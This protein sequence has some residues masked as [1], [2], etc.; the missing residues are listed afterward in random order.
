MKK[1]TLFLVLLL[2][3]A[4][5]QS[6][7]TLSQ[8]AD[9]A[10]IDV[11]GI[12]CWG[13]STGQYRDNAFARTYDL[14]SFGITGAWSISSVE[15]GQGSG[16][17]GKV[18]QVNLYTSD[19]ENLTSATLTSVYTTDVTIQSANDMSLISVP[20][21]DVVIPA[22]SIVV[23]EV[24]A[25]DE[26]TTTGM[27]F[28]PGFN[29]SGENNTPWIKSDGCDIT[30]TDANTIITGSPQ[31]YVINIVGDD[32]TANVI[33]N[34]SELTEIYPNPISNELKVDMPS[35][36][37][38]ENVTLFDLLGKNTGLRLENNTINTE[39]LS[40]G[41]YFLNIKTDVGEITKKII[42]K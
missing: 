2:T 5:V 13:A 37:N 22:N 24:F 35:H 42:K 31:P 10:T 30:W 20:I 19:S 25:P 8:S 17:D 34:L 9:P 4:I 29:L 33:D 39:N 16:D 26:G 41:V 6:Q 11:G 36:I 7:V 28:F 12:A 15:F 32:A 14:A 21:E 27:T 38:I 1:F 18:V 40:A 23:V 3:S